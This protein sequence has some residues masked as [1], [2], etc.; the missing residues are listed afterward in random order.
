MHIAYCL[1]QVKRAR[2]GQVLKGK[3]E[4]ASSGGE[5]VGEMLHC[6]MD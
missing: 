2:T 1:L 5:E 4:E 6:M 3:L